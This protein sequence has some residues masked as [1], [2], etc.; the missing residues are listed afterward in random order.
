VINFAGN[1]FTAAVRLGLPSLL[2]AAYWRFRGVGRDPAAH[3]LKVCWTPN[4][5]AHAAHTS[6]K[7]LEVW[8]C[9][10]KIPAVGTAGNSQVVN[11]SLGKSKNVLLQ[12]EWQSPSI[13]VP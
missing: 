13:A 6:D 5:T 12:I 4:R 2:A 1:P 9:R 10:K 11:A 3:R 7:E 8:S